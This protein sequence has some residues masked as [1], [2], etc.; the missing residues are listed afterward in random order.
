MGTA[1]AWLRSLLFAPLFY[2][3]TVLC[4]ALAGVGALVSE[5][6]MRAA[7]NGWG[8]QHRV[9]ARL[10]LGQKIRVIGDLPCGPMLYVFKHESMFETIDL[11][12]LLDNPIAIA[13]QELLDIPGWGTLAR[14]YGMI[15]L[16]RSEG[17]K[18]LRH[19][20]REVAS[21]IGSGRPICLFPEGT[22][23]P[24]GQSPPIKSGFA[25]LYQLLGLPVVPVAVD[26]GRLS[27]RNSLLKRPGTIT[28]KVGEIVPPG[29][30]R[31]EAEARVHAAINALNATG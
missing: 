6:L 5:R 25:A 22:R 28:Y 1:I 27:P 14:H 11:L 23:V 21:A 3:G 8:W 2:T 15:G 26:S 19:L 24:H 20:K 10:V 30:P 4:V 31:D 29:L 16:R 18:A 17:A 9:L 7:V 13:K 12:C